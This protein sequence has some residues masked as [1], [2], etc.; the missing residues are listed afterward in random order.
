MPHQG[1]FYLTSP[2]CLTCQTSPSAAAKGPR[3][4]DRCPRHHLLWGESRGGGPTPSGD[5][6]NVAVTTC[7]RVLPASG[8]LPPDR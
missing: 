8:T 2:T 1:A 6:S 7:P 3:T 5:G 4:T